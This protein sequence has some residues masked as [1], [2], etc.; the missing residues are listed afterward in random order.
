M[1]GYSV[2]LNRDNFGRHVNLLD[3]EDAIKDTHYEEL[4]V[5][6]DNKQLLLVNGNVLVW[7]FS[8]EILKVLNKKVYGC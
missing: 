3:G 1:R 6:C 4:A 7:G 5:L 2:I 8:A